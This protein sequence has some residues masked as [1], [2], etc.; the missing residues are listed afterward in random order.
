MVIFGDQKVSKSKSYNLLKR[1]FDKVNF[2]KPI[3]RLGYVKIDTEQKANAHDA[4][5]QWN[6]DIAEGK[7]IID[8]NYKTMAKS[9]TPEQQADLTH[10]LELRTRTPGSRGPMKKID[11]ET[12]KKITELLNDPNAANDP[13][14]SHAANVI[15]KRLDVIHGMLKK[16]NPDIGFIEEYIPHMWESTSKQNKSLVNRLGTRIPFEKGRF[17]PTYAEGIEMGLKPRFKSALDLLKIYENTAIRA[18]ANFNLAQNMRAITNKDGHKMLN[19]KDKSPDWPT[20]DHWALGK[21]TQV[22]PEIYPFVNAIFS[23]RF[24]G[25]NAS[26]K[27]ASLAFSAFHVGALAESGI[28]MGQHPFAYK[29]GKKLIDTDPHIVR[30]ALRHGLQIDVTADAQKQR[31]DKLLNKWANANV[32]LWKQAGKGVQAYKN[33]FDTAMWENYHTGHKLAAYHRHY[34]KEL[35][36]SLKKKDGRSSEA[37]G[38]EIAQFVNDAFGGQNW[39]LLLKSQKWQ[40]LGSGIFLAPDWTMS[41]LR[42]AANL[43]PAR[44]ARGYWIRAALNYFLLSNMMNQVMVRLDPEEKKYRDDNDLSYNMY[45]N[46]INHKVDIYWGRDAE[47]REEYTHIGKQFREPLRYVTDPINIIGSKLSPF[48]RTAVEQGTGATTTAFPMKW[49]ENKWG[50]TLNDTEKWMARFVSVGEKFVP[51]SFR[52]GNKWFTFPSSK[53]IT[54]YKAIRQMQDTFVQGDVQTRSKVIAAL[55][56][57]NFTNVEVKNF[58]KY[59]RSNASREEKMRAEGL[60]LERVGLGFFEDIRQSVRPSPSF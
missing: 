59:A 23:E 25:A 38:R 4:I 26:L 43:R 47:G 37:I 7:Y 24:G 45:D 28:A 27:A 55:Y 11:I 2:I 33:W 19:T 39:E 40:Q 50:A 29:R 17:I 20:V 16:M 32:P 3:K 54:P 60:I 44:K 52:Q 42:I 13:A 18:V 22:D 58:K 57:N 10:V 36:R 34:A 49:S 31:V 5:Y 1:F 9:L 14:V 6:G 53:G 15:R 12:N 30:G 8:Q 41:N 56:K 46:T 35:A 51:F 21:H 48:V